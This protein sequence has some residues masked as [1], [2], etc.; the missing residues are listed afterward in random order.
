M[1]LIILTFNNITD[2][3][4]KLNLNFNAM[5]NFIENYKNFFF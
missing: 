2:N 3:K 5:F 4:N 1:Y